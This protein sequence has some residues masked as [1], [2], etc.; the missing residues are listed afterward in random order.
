MGPPR[1]KPRKNAASLVGKGVQQEGLTRGPL[2]PRR[3]P[4]LA[5]RYGEST[6]AG[7]D[8]FHRFS[9]FIKNPVPTQD[10]GEAALEAWRGWGE[11]AQVRTSLRPTPQPCT[12]CCCERSP[13]WTA[14]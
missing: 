13:G 12:R 10:D 4:S 9:A 5:P 11:L 6:T 8:V 2:L 7:N 14:T 1:E 3:F